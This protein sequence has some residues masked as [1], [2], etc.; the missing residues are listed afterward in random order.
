M[1]HIFPQGRTHIV[2]HMRQTTDRQESAIEILRAELKAIQEWPTL[3]LRT[4]TEMLAVVFREV[5][6]REI[7]EKIAQIALM[8]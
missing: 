5:R 4:A 7:K 3:E 2:C 6:A 8:N 1:R